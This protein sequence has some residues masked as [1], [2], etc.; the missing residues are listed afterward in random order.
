[1]S[2]PRRTLVA[3]LPEKLA[4]WWHSARHEA[5]TEQLPV[6]L[7]RKLAALGLKA[8][9]IEALSPAVLEDLKRNCRACPD[10]QRCIDDMAVDPLAPGWESYCPNSGTLSTL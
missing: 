7:G 6:L 4:E 5:D 1:M 3:E 10:R 8:E 9:E 2:E